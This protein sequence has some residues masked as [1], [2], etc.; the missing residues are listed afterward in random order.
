MIVTHYPRRDRKSVFIV[1]FSSG[2]PVIKTANLEPLTVN[3]CW[4]ADHG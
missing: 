1:G 3:E 4:Y 2:V